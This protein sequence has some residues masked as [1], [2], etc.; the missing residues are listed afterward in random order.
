MNISQRRKNYGC[1]SNLQEL[2]KES[3]QTQI[4]EDWYEAIYLKQINHNKN[5][6]S[7]PQ[8]NKKKDKESIT[9]TITKWTNIYYTLPTRNPLQT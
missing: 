8:F 2:P 6:S 9:K 4:P 3:H 5:F 7:N 1:K